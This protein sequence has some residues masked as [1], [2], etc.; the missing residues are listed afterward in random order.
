LNK[1][2]K[3]FWVLLIKDLQLDLRSL[4]GFVAAF[5]L[6]VIFSVFFAISLQRSFIPPITILKILPTILWGIVIIV[7]TATFE[8]SYDAEIQNEA[9][10]GVKQSRLPLY[11]VYLSKLTVG[12]IKLFMTWL[13]ALTIIASMLNL[14]VEP[15]LTPFF[16]GVVLLG[17]IGLSSLSSLLVA[18]TSLSKLKGV[19]FA[20]LFIP[21]AMPLVFS[22]LELTSESLV[23]SESVVSSWLGLLIICDLVYLLVGINL[24]E[25]L[26]ET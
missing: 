5:L 7:C 15:L 18:V 21:L 20:I 16:L 25:F 1:Q 17:S 19:I 2:L 14:V 22:L 9:W 23:V 6:V 3:F 11:L 8:R 24:Y 10:I 12:V 26:Y 4:G 13:L